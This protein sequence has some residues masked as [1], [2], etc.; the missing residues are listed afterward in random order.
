MNTVVLSGT[1]VGAVGLLIILMSIPFFAHRKNL[2]KNCTAE[3]MGTVVKYRYSGGSGRVSVA[4]K[5]EFDVDGKT[6]KA[7]RHYKGV[8]SVQKKTIDPKKFLGQQDYFY[9]GNNDIFYINT[10]GVMHDYKKLGEQVWPIGTKLPVKYNPNKP[11]QAFVEKVV[12]TSGIVGICLCGVGALLIAI[13]ALVVIFL[14]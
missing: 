13:A 11:K 9:I 8:S 10:A 6:Y 7:Y 2:K 3:A 4:P 5:V 1:I 12:T 14:R